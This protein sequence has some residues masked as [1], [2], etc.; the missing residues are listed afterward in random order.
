MTGTGRRLSSDM[1]LVVLAVLA[2]ASILIVN[3]GPLFY[4]DTVGYY[5]QGTKAL[6]QLGFGETATGG[7]GAEPAIAGGRTVDGSRSPFY[8]LVAAL[9][10]RVGLFEGLLLFNALALFGALWLM[11]R[12]VHRLCLPEANQTEILA[13]PVIFA[14]FGSLPFYAAYLMPDLMAPVLLIVLALFAAFARDMRPGEMFLAVA[15]GS[16]A[17]VSH[18]SHLAI[19]AAM[20]PAVALVS[21]IMAR[22]RW[23]LAP[24]LALVVFGAGGLQQVAFRAVAQ[25]AA[26]SDVV[27]RPFLTAR[28]IQ[29]GPGYSWLEANCPDETVPTCKLWE[30]LQLSDDPYRLTASHIVFER[31]KRLGSFMLMSEDDQKAVADAQVGFYIAVARDMPVAVTVA[32]LANVFRQTAMV[33]IDMTLQSDKMVLVNERIGGTLSN[34]LDHG[35]IT[36][37]RGWVDPLVGMHQVLYAI[38]AAVAFVMI[39]MRG[40]PAALRAFAVAILLGILANAFVCAGLSQPATRYGARVIWLLPLTAAL[41]V[42]WMVRATR[43]DG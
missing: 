12:L 39:L 38:S 10:A 40:V 30:A 27:I 29:D 19:G 34:P 43:E 33:S 13:V 24:A 1:A 22:R 2:V 37:S 14:A 6:Q 5:D 28:L 21:L 16:V 35:R 31:S 15:L 32:L 8:S 4:Y 18:L 9:L 23:W 11:A 36:Q 41:L 20:V 17:I 25:K 3:G 7:G 42:L 26:H